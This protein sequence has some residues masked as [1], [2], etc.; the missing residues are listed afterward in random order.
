MSGA[1]AAGCAVEDQPSSPTATATAT[2]GATGGA[3]TTG[4]E[5]KTW[6]QVEAAAAEEGELTVYLASQDGINQRLVEAFEDAYPGIAVNAIRL[7]SGASTARVA[8]EIESGAP[9]ADVVQVADNIALEEH[10]DWFLQLAGIPNVDAWPAERVVKGYYVHHQT[11]PFVITYNTELVPGGPPENWADLADFG[12]IGEGL[13]IDPR[14]ANSFMAMAYFLREQGGDEL[15]EALGENVGGITDSSASAAQQ[16]AAGE[17]ALAFPNTR[18]H[19]NVARSQGA[20]VDT[21]A[22]QPSLAVTNIYTIPAAGLNH[23][24]AAVFLNFVLSKAGAQA[25]CLDGDY[26][27]FAY[28]DL[29]TCAKA[30]DDLTLVVDIYPK[31][32]NEA[33]AEISDLL[34]LD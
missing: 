28:D 25:T 34:G 7:E 13:M 20:P 26:Q 22:G 3:Q 16:V 27:S 1:V 18:E 14:A 11:A 21:V 31:L 15:L 23:N 2:G 32:S 10:P 4:F 12:A 6:E 9:T 33:R 17:I 24:A 8:A 5:G 29:P 30:Q 19:T